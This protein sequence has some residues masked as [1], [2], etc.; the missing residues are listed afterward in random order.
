MRADL[1]KGKSFR[2]NGNCAHHHWLWVNLSKRGAGQRGSWQEQ[3]HPQFEGSYTRWQDEK[4]LHGVD[5][6]DQQQCGVT[7]GRCKLGCCCN[8]LRQPRN[9]WVCFDF[10]CSKTNCCQSSFGIP[11]QCQTLNK[12]TKASCGVEFPPHPHFTTLLRS[13]VASTRSHMEHLLKSLCRD[14]D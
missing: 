2:D 11:F 8:W 3:T 14:P 1:M 12:V 6:Q 13:H 4:F 7:R 9:T 5:L 10:V